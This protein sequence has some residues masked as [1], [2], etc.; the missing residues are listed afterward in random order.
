MLP[1]VVGGVLL[2]LLLY[3]SDAWGRF[4][5]RAS[6]APL[7]RDLHFQLRHQHA[8]TLKGGVV[9]SDVSRSQLSVSSL[10]GHTLRSKPIKTYRPSSVAAHQRTLSRSQLSAQSELEPLQWDED[11]VPAPDVESRDTLLELAK[12]TYNAY[13]DHND[14]SWYDLDGKWNVVGT[15]L[16][17]Y[18]VKQD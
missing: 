1:S 14:T 16:L 18:I 15:C 4:L 5:P 12:M 6:Q 17:P 3:W 7:T 11:E 9:F 8:S 2:P 13:V 10:S